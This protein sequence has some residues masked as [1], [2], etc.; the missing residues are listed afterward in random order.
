MGSVPIDGHD[1]ADPAMIEGKNT[2][3]L[4]QQE[5]RKALVSIG[6]EC[7]G[8]HHEVP[9]EPQREAEIIETRNKFRIGNRR[10]SYVK[11]GDITF[12]TGS[13]R[14]IPHNILSRRYADNGTHSRCR[15]DLDGD[16]PPLE[17]ADNPPETAD[18]G[19]VRSFHRTPAGRRSG[20][21]STSMVEPYHGAPSVR[22][23]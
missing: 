6:T 20:S 19:T 21:S 10:P 15:R 2:R 12:D 17:P 11:G 18:T 1:P 14:R 22:S 4:A 7:P 8:R 16:R 9:L 3:M 13:R 5:N 23:S